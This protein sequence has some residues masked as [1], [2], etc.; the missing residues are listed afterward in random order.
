[1][2]LR[3]N[4][5]VGDCDHATQK[6]PE[7]S[8]RQTGIQTLRRAM[9][10][11]IVRWL[12]SWFFVCCFV[13]GASTNNSG[14][15]CYCPTSNLLVSFSDVSDSGVMPTDESCYDEVVEATGSDICEFSESSPEKLCQKRGKCSFTCCGHIIP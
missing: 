1:M 6:A 14:S 15:R 12:C 2:H 10:C 5:M 8:N 13:S 11:I 9:S 7:V 4:A 3:S